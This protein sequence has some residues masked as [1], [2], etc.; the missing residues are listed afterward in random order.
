MGKNTKGIVNWSGGEMSSSLKG[1][2]DTVPYYAMAETLENVLC[3]HYGSVFKT[4]G[5][6]HLARTK[7]IANDSR[8]IPFIFS[9]GQSYMLE[10]GDSYIRFFQGGGSMVETAVNISAATKADPCVVTTSTAHGYSNGDAIDIESVGGMTELNEKRFLVAN[11]TSNTMELQDEDGNDIDSSAYTTYT[12]GG[13]TER[14]Y[15]ITSPYAHDDLSEIKYTQQADIMY[16]VHPDYAPRKLSRTSATTFTIS[17]ITYDSLDIPPFLSVD[18]S[19]TTITPSETTGSITL[20]ASASLFESTHVGAY[21]KLLHGTTYGYAKVT[22]FTSAT[23]VDATV[24]IDFGAS[25]AADS[26]Y[27]GAWSDK[28]GWPTDVKFYE[29]RL[30]Y[31][32]TTYKPLT[33]WGSKFG[34]Y[35]NFDQGS[36]DDDSV[37]YTL[38]SAQVD[39]IRWLYPTGVLNCGTAGGPF[40]LSSG[41]AAEPITPTNVSVKQQNENGTSMV[42]PVRI[43]SYVYYTE[44]SDKV[45]GQLTYNLDTDSFVTENITYLS[46]HILGGGVVEMA[47]QRYPYNILWCVLTDGTMATMTREIKNNVKGWTRQVF[48]GTDAEIKSVGV[49]PSGT[50]D[51][52]WLIEERTINS[53]SVKHITIVQPHEFTNQDDAWF[54]QD[55]LEYDGTATTTITGLDHLEGES[56]QLL[57]DGAVHPNKTVSSGSVTLEWLGS[58][59]IAGLGYTATLKT[60]DIDTANTQ[61]TAQGKVTHI[62]EV[63]LRFLESLGCKFGDGTT[64]DTLTFRSASANMDEPPELYTGDKLVQFP[65]DHVRNKYIKVTQEQ[66]LPFHL[67]GIFP[68][69]SIS[70]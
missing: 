29:Q 10:F 51:Q 59:V 17:T 1:R 26:W 13:T 31:C 15:E 20:T 58:H 33:L 42:S 53:V 28:Q 14:I 47:L 69:M 39:K 66:P 4:P 57:V 63:I 23:V 52:I 60:L 8:L 43:G 38:G 36:N 11:V 37:Q 16:I 24:I 64:M 9:T 49:I 45:L 67:L 27:E 70:Y 46:D 62:G 44:R 40:T 2:T 21:F 55:G 18:T 6:K 3:T 56:V 25:T 30:Y 32:G 5:T 19:T 7:T 35:D 48:G 65:S 22:G 50:E 68:E 61:Q 12:S 34:E 54:V 41:S